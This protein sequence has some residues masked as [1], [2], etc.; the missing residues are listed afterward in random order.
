MITYTYI[1]VRWEDILIVFTAAVFA[2]QFLRRKVIVDK[3]FFILV[4]IFWVLVMASFA[5]GFYLTKTI[6]KFQLGLLNALRRIEYLITFFIAFTTVRSRKDLLFYLDVICFVAGIVTIY[7]LGQKFLGWPAVQTMNPEYAK[8]YILILDSASRISSTFGGHYDLAAYLVFLMP[9]VIAMS[10][11][12]KNIVFLGVFI[13]MVLNL[14]FTASRISFAAYIVSILPFAIFLKKPK[15]LLFIIAV[16]IIVTPLS[17]TLTQ[18]LSRTFQEKKVFIDEQTGESKIAQ[19]IT[20]EELPAGDSTFMFNTKAVVGGVNSVSQANLK[21]ED[22][23]AVKVRILDEV[24][25]E[26]TKT[27]KI[28]TPKEENEMVDEAFNKLTL[29]TSILPDIS[30]ATRLQVEWPRAVKAFLKYPFLGKGPS[31]LTE[32]SDNNY[33]RV[34]G[35]FGGLGFIAFMAIFVVI[36]KRTFHTIRKAVENDDRILYLAFLFGMFAIMINA[37]YMDI[38]EASKDAYHLWLLAGIFMAAIPFIPVVKTL[39]H[40]HEKN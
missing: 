33:L 24:R 25:H 15:V 1:A 23:T 20:A 35:E 12:R 28:L 31:T 16:T 29:V 32:A 10:V 9:V 17:N 11:V 3:V 5:D 19:K 21:P 4:G 26:A 39:K 30:F 40:A 36:L 8:G 38:F 7:G 27:G 37:T 2:I 22:I 6:P 13:L 18:R 34:L 14:V